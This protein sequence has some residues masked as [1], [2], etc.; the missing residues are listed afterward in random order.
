MGRGRKVLQ[1]I[2][3]NCLSQ[4]GT[5]KRKLALEDENM[6]DTETIEHI[7]KKNKGGGQEMEIERSEEGVG[8]SFHWTPSDP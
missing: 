7:Q 4:V 3:G 2:D 6:T 1:Q 8:A 5:T